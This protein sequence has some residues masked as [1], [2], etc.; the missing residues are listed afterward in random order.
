VKLLQGDLAE[1][2]REGDTDYATVAMKFALKDSTVESASDAPSKAAAERGH[3][4]VDLHARARRQLAA[5]CHPA[6][7]MDEN[8]VCRAGKSHSPRGDCATLIG[9]CPS[10]NIEL[11]YNIVLEAVSAA[12]GC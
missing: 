9:S 1:A 4:I 11:R 5:L 2:W 12:S 7:L 8:S 3:W 6:D 10:A